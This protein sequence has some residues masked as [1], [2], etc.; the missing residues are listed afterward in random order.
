MLQYCDKIIVYIANEY[1]YVSTVYYWISHVSDEVRSYLNDHKGYEAKGML[2]TLY[3]FG[4]AVC[5]LPT[6]IRY[7]KVLMMTDRGEEAV[8]IVDDILEVLRKDLPVTFEECK[9]LAKKYFAQKQYV[10]SILFDLLGNSLLP[11]VLVE[12]KKVIGIAKNM[13]R[14]GQSLSE[15][16][17]AH[18]CD[19]ALK[20][21]ILP[22]IRSSLAAVFETV[23]EKN[24]K[25]TATIHVLCKHV[26][27]IMEGTFG[28]VEAVEKTLKDALE[29]M[30]SAS[31]EEAEKSHVFGTVLNNL[32]AATLQQGKIE[33]AKDLFEQ[34]ISVNSDATDYSTEEER[35]KDVARST[36]GLKKVN[37]ILEARQRTTRNNAPEAAKKEEKQE[38]PQKV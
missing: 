9:R 34:A 1:S 18:S 29:L 31:G 2:Q 3:E 35:K 21:F 5:F 33:E 28:D 36:T 24:R 4:P 32:G 19:N 20:S 10:L 27:Q 26:V 7:F 13:T 6:K 22:K 16:R 12:E 37:E 11:D 17:K 15:V 30:K 38:Q 25:K 8:Q 23:G 14:L